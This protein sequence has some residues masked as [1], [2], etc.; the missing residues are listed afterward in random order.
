M[1]YSCKDHI[2]IAM[3]E[4]VD[5]TGMPPDLQLVNE[6]EKE[7]RHCSFCNSEATYKIS[8]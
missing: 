4:M 6:A 3:E 8:G 1:Y 5:E 2:D 7:E